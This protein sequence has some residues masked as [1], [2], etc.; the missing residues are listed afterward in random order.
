MYSTLC[1]DYNIFVLGIRRAVE[2]DPHKQSFSRFLLV[3]AEAIGVE[4]ESEAVEKQ[5][6]PHHW[7]RHI[8]FM[9]T[10]LGKHRIVI[11]IIFGKWLFLPSTV[12][13]S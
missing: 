7:W 10:L 11:C 6:L 1:C 2:T 9:G 13:Y 5:P 12:F 3:K 4:A 8:S